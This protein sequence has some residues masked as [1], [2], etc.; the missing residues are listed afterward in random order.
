M[1]FLVL[2]FW[3]VI[4]ISFTGSA[5]AESHGAWTKI[6]SEY[7]VESEDGINRFDY[8][9][10]K[11]TR[12]DADALESYIDTLS[13]S[14][15]FENG[16]RDEQFAAWAN[17]YNAVTVNLIVN[18]YP[19]KSIRSLGP[20]GILGPWD[21]KL[22]DRNGEKLTLNN[23]EHDI[24]RKQWSDPRVH[25]AVNCASIGCPNLQNKAW[26]AETLDSDLNEAAKEFIN[27][28]RG[29]EVLADGRLK[30]SKI[31]KWFSEDFGNSE[32]GTVMHFMKYASPEL[33]SQLK[34]ETMIKSSQYDWSLNEIKK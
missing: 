30:I 27:H 15:V 32:V 26:E 2:S 10:L 24:L 1:R 4:C 5:V 9:R 17:L 19:V 13:D 29:V 16:T 14:D 31:Y 12:E 18:K 28:P 11:E 25:Y 3:T 23:V 33:A 6:L 22:I 34:A 20:F 7:V 21:K 8:A